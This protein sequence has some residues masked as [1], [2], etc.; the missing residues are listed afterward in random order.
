VA[1]GPRPVMTS[2]LALRAAVRARE[3]PGDCTG[4]TAARE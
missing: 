4:V 3:T 2:S 1:Y